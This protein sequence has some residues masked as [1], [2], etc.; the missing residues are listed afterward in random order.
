MPAPPRADV[1]RP[2]TFDDVHAARE[3]LRPYLAPTP[4]RSC[5]REV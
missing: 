2:I 3:R 1:G 4:L 5:A